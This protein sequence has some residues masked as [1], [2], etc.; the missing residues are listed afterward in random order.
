[1]ASGYIRKDGVVYLASVDLG[2]D[3]LTGKRRERSETFPTRRE[4]RAAIA[5][6]QTEIDQGTFVDRSAQTVADL[7]RYWME[8]YVKHNRSE[9]TYVNYHYQVDGHLM[10]ALGY[11]QVQKLTAA[12]VQQFYADSLESGVGRRTVELC[13]LCLHR[14][15]DMAVQ[16]GIVGKNVTDAVQPPKALLVERNAWTREQTRRFLAV[17]RDSHYG[18]IWLLMATTG[19]RRGEV[20]G[21]RWASVDLDAGVVDIR[22]ALVAINGRMKETGPKGGKRRTI[23]LSAEMVDHLRAHK[24]RQ[25]KRRADLGN[26]WVDNDLVFTSEV[27]TPINARNLDREFKRFIAQVGVPEIPIHSVRHTVGTLLVASGEDVRTVADV[28][29]HDPRVLLRTYAHVVAHRKAEVVNTISGL[30]LGADD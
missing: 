9:N 3:P 11:I 5:R 8:T 23:P 28:L 4:A 24:A 13:H 27:G 2:K 6:W 18:P 12:Q 10:P 22:R 16:L 29:G 17:A 21:L 7:L 19:M 20:L 25:G 15:L 30:V 1:M 14:A 26:V